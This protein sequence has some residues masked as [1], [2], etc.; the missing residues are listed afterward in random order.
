M[1]SAAK[2]VHASPCITQGGY[3]P[4]TSDQYLEELLKIDPV[5]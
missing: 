4:V 1:A 5:I 3:S 2:G